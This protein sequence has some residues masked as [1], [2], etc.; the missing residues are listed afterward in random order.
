[1]LWAGDMSDSLV[2]RASQVFQYRAHCEFFVDDDRAH[3]IIVDGAIDQY[4]WDISFNT[5]IND[6]IFTMRG[7]NDQTLD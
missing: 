7:S 5:L 4:E 6:G 3:V 2:I 1:M